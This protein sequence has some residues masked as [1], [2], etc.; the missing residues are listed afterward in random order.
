MELVQVGVVKELCL[1]PVKSMAELPV[2]DAYLNWHGLDGDRKYAFVQ[3]GNTTDFPWLTARQAPEMLHYAPYFVAPS[4]RAR[5]AIQVRTPDGDDLP[6]QSAELVASLA[7]HFPAGFHL[8]QLGTGAFDEF[9]I[10][11]LSTATLIG[12]SERVGFPVPGNRFRPNIIVEP[13][14]ALDAIED[15][16]VTRTLSFGTGPDAPQMTVS[17]RDP[18]CVMVNYDRQTLQQT[19]ALLREIAQNR[20]STTGVYGSILEPGPINVGDPVFLA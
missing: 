5:S 10:S 2:T 20:S 6:L 11:L 7:V 19:P 14:E 8:V 9:P 16:W 1:Y 17:K 3:D 12:L 15:R 18:R 13:L 4:D